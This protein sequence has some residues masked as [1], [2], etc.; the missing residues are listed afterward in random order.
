MNFKVFVRLLKRSEE[1]ANQAGTPAIV[2]R[3]YKERVEGP[4]NAFLSANDTLRTVLGDNSK[5]NAEAASALKAIDK[6]YS[7]ARCAAL[8]YMPHLVLPETLK[9]VRT[10]TDK[11]DAIESL[12]E[13]LEANGAAGWSQDLLGGDF[14]RLAPDTIREIDEAIQ[15]DASLTAARRAR[16]QAFGPAYEAY[17]SFKRV[18]RAACG[19]VSREY[20][21][22]H[23]RST[24]SEELDE[25]P[26]PSAE[27]T[28]PT[29]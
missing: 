9:A 16:A 18:V 10:D 22:I 4:A 14:G 12:Q 25:E 21:R 23:M 20:R 29:A 26:T 2:A 8:A 27:P 3:V 1:L 13:V 28:A 11:M 6:P 5:E 19:S 17:L 15:A 24:E 7:V